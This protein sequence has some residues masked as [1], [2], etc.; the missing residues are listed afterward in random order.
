MIRSITFKLI[1]NFKLPSCVPLCLKTSKHIIA[2]INGAKLLMSKTKV[3]SE[4]VP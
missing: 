2:A 1:E 4:I 3:L